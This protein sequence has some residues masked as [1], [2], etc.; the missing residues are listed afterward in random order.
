MNCFPT[1]CRSGAA[2]TSALARVLHAFGAIRWTAHVAAGGDELHLA[3][4]GQSRSTWT[5]RTLPHLPGPSGRQE[6]EHWFQERTREL[7]EAAGAVKI[8]DPPI[9]PTDGGVHLLGTARMGMIRATRSST[10]IIAR[11]TFRTCS[12]ATAAASS[13]PA[14]PA[15]DDDPGPRLPRCRPY[16]AVRA[17]ARHLTDRA[18]RLYFD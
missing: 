11:T 15:D 3:R 8:W 9:L 2:N 4:P 17:R 14:R 12:S 5:S 18:H 7:M 10:D 1:A 13:R 16:H 6:D